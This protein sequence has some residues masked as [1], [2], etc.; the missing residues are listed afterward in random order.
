MEEDYETVVAW[1][2]QEEKTRS[3]RGQGVSSFYLIL[4]SIF[5]FIVCFLIL[6]YTNR[7]RKTE[8]TTIDLMTDPENIYEEEFTS[9]VED[10]DDEEAVDG[11]IEPVDGGI[12][13]EKV[14]TNEA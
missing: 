5:V 1:A 9:N 3:I 6:Y 13:V 11:G 12:E 7:G 2:E 14:E 10:E 8:L 4:G